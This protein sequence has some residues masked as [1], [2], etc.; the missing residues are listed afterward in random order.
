MPKTKRKIKKANK[1][2]RPACG[3]QTRKKIKT[4]R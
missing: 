2:H 1:G 3:H 4:P